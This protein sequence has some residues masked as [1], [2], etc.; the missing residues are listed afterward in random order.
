MHISTCV[1]EDGSIWINFNAIGKWHYS[2]LPLE[3]FEKE[4][5]CV[6]LSNQEGEMFRDAK[7]R[8]GDIEFKLIHDD[9][10][11]NTISTHNHNDV[12]TL[13]NLAINVAECIIDLESKT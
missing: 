10:F 5:N 2:P 1:N 12:S 11:G 7:L 3:L 13:E 9:L 8:L 6:I 4:C